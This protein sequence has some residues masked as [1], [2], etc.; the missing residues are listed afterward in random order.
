[1][2]SLEFNKN[3]PDN[4]RGLYKEKTVHLIECVCCRL[5]KR[6]STEEEAVEAWNRRV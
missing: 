1:M 2:T 3:Y 6:F 4:G 5:A